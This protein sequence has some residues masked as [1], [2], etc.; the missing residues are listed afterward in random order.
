MKNMP[1]FIMPLIFERK[2]WNS[3]EEKVYIAIAS[4]SQTFEYLH[5]VYDFSDE[6]FFKRS[7]L[8]PLEIEQYCYEHGL[9]YRLRVNKMR[10]TRI[11]IYYDISF[12]NTMTNPASNIQKAYFGNKAY[13]NMYR[14][15]R[16]YVQRINE[17]ILH[18]Q[19]LTNEGDT[20][21][22]AVIYIN[23][24]NSNEINKEF[25]K[26]LIKNFEYCDYKYE[27]TD[28]ELPA[29]KVISWPIYRSKM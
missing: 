12:P 18:I 17:L 24:E 5:L 7:E 9:E 16:E 8:S 14:K 21:E 29:L 15:N 1:E 2:R 23:K 19:I 4:E 28:C 26:F 22:C 3:L 10:Y 11:V 6:A 13:Y 20:S 27:F 25:E